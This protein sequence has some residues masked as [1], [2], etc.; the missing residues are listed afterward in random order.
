MG[1]SQMLLFAD[2]FQT[3]FHK[4][5]RDN[6]PVLIQIMS[7]RRTNDHLVYGAC[8]RHSVSMSKTF[9]LGYVFFSIS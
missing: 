2:I 9:H 8:L 4:G 1:S 3:V 5:S 7:K 6:N